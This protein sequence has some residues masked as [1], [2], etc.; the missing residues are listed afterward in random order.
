[1]ITVQRVENEVDAL[2]RKSAVRIVVLNEIEKKPA[3]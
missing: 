2:N 1:M 3:P